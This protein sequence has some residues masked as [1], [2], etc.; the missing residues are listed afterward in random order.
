MEWKCPDCGQPHKIHTPKL[1]TE[2]DRVYLMCDND[3]CCALLYID[4]KRSKD[5]PQRHAW[6]IPAGRAKT[7][8]A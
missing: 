4:V 5:S 2:G 8:A 7:S 6:G 1:V 3:D